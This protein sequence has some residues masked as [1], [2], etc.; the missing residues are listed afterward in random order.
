MPTSL[1][2]GAFLAAAAVVLSASPSRSQTSTSTNTTGTNTPGFI[3]SGISGQAQSFGSPNSGVNAPANVNPPSGAYAGPA[4]PYTNPAG[5]NSIT[6]TP[7]GNT[8]GNY[9]GYGGYYP[10][11]G[12]YESDIGGYLRG[13]ADIITAQGQWFKDVQNA[14]A[15][16][17]K[18]KQ[19]ILATRRKKLEEYLYERERTPTAED[20]RQRQLQLQINRSLNDPPSSEIW[21]GQA[22]NN[23]IADIRKVEEKNPNRPSVNIDDDVLR[24]INLSPGMGNPG[25]LRNEGRLHWP[26]TLQGD[27][28]KSQRELLNSLAPE[29]VRQAVNGRVDPGSLKDMVDSVAKMR[30]TLAANIRDLTPNQFIE[31]NR[32]LSQFDDALKILGRPDAGDL[33]RPQLAGK[34]TSVADLLKYMG[35]KGLLFAPAVAG[36]ESAYAAIHR[37][38]VAYDNEV[39]GNPNP[40]R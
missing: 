7:Y 6:T 9:G 35:D 3:P 31:A 34:S 17:E 28:F 40:G 13:T 19:E 26:L 14:L 39:K 25:L 36:D 15:M 10:P 1:K 21:S 12:Y 11:Y 37:A 18:Y 16:K 8:S 24:H 20:E 30:Q 5:G 2:V 32:F 4:N 27:D 29:A 23:I 38:L 22:L 33:I